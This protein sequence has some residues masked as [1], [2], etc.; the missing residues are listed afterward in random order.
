[1]PKTDAI[2]ARYSSDA[3]SEGSSIEIQIEACTKLLGGS[4]KVY[5]DEARTGRA[6]AGRNGLASLLS[7]AK[8]GRI[9]RLCV[10]RF[11]RIGRNLK[12]ASEVLQELEDHDVQ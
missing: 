8:A 12:E 11:S 7:D 10:W 2:Y 3:Q 6:R 9:G 5:A 1:M 4:P